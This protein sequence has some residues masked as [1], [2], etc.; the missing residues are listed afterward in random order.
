MPLATYVWFETRVV[1]FATAPLSGIGPEQTIVMMFIEALA[2]V[3]PMFLFVAPAIWWAA[4]MSC[5]VK[6]LYQ[7]VRS[8]DQELKSLDR[9][10]KALDRDISVI[11]SDLAEIKL[12]IVK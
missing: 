6:S 9:N 12:V 2:D 7:D 5:D 11:K 3:W 4:T 1:T 10:V 8:F